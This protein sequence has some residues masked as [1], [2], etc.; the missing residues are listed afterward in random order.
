MKKIFTVF[1]VFVLCIS[2]LVGCSSST[3]SSK[4]GK[5]IQLNFFHRWPTQP[6]KA[7]FEKAVK[8]FEKQHPNIKIKTEAVLNDSYKEK[9]RVVLGSSNPPDI[10]F[11]WSGEF[12]YNF[13]RAGKALDLTDMIKEDTGWSDQIIQSQFIP[14][15]LDG[16][17][18]GVPWSMDGKS[19]FYNK[20]IFK[21]LNLEEPKTWTEFMDDLQK[22]KDA[23]ITPIAF[24]SKAPWTI[25]HYIGTLNQRL[26]PQ[27][28]IKVDYDPKNPEGDFSNPGYVEALK[29]FK[30][31]EPYF[32]KGVNAVDHEYARQLFKSGKAAICYMQYAEIGMVEPALKDDLGVFKLPEIEGG[33]GDPNVITGAPEGIMISSKT[34]YP[35]EAMEFIKFLTSKEKGIQQ[36][37]EVNEYS[38]TKGTLTDQ[39]SSPLQQKAVDQ[40]VNADRTALWL[41][42]DLD[43]KIVD[44]YLKGAQLMLDGKKTPEEV[45]KDVQKAAKEVKQSAAK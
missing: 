42:T 24:G 19:F 15:T 33:K 30:E 35:K 21:Q 13:A 5:V 4:D 41:D 36:V 45:M 43:I 39:N 2:V 40:I 38:A 10:F 23:N 6:K 7:F 34:K 25:S 3:S 44:A 31:L 37:K 14:F 11:S 16:K 26:V 9:I 32:N 29:K 20:K 22:I 27:E 18:Y 8:E 12:A 28:I 1:T 17:T